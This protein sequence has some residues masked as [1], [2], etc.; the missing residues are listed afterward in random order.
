MMTVKT[1]QGFLLSIFCGWLLAGTG[2]GCSD[3]DTE[4]SSGAGDS[5]ADSDTDSDT[6]SD[7]DTDSDTDTDS[8]SDTDADGDTGTDTSEKICDEV[9]FEINSKM[10][11]I[12][13]VLD[14]SLSMETADLWVPMGQALTEVT[15]LTESNVNFGLMTFPFTDEQCAPGD[16][17]IDVGPLNAAAI[18]DVVGGGPN[19]VGCALGTPTA[20]TLVTAKEYLDGLDDGLEKYV[21]LANDGA[22]NCNDDVEVEGCRCTPPNMMGQNC[23]SAWMCLDDVATVDAA[24]ALSSS[25]YAVFVLGMG[26]SMEWG[27]VMD[28]IAEAGGTNE[29]LPVDDASL[30]EETLLTLIGGLMSCE[31]EVDWESLSGDAVQDPNMVN[32]FCKQ[33]VDDASDLDPVT[34]NV[35]PVNPGCAPGTDG[36]AR[37]WDWTDDTHTSVRMCEDMCESLKNNDCP[38]ITATFGCATVVIV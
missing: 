9:N 28:A 23:T 25:G 11:D 27:D 34:G 2:P 17:L 13:I 18:A 21:L 29:Y 1:R 4:R 7:A 12:L 3:S 24:T 6:D 16:V 22:P 31:F 5:D 26:D 33:S 32:F 19:D 15:A 14:R 30:L 35:I 38:V 37:G 36:A 10:V 20:G 8:D